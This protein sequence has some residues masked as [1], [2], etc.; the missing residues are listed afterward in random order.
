MYDCLSIIKEIYLQDYTEILKY[1][2]L[3]FQKIFK[4]CLL[5]IKS[6]TNNCM[7]IV[8]VI[9]YYERVK[10]SISMTAKFWYIKYNRFQVFQYDH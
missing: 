7:E 10:S 6:E 5:I 3:N 4:K 8:I 9:P 2:F 1:L